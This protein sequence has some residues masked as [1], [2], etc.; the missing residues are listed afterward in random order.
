MSKRTCEVN[1]KTV[2]GKPLLIAACENGIAMEKM[3]L[4]LLEQGADAHAIDQ[5]T[6]RTALH[7]ACAGGLIN[8][9]RELL[10]R[11]ADVNARDNQQQTPAHAAITSKVFEVRRNGS[12]GLIDRS[13]SCQFFL[14]T[15]HVLIWAINR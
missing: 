4:M 12:K 1:G 7:A 6:G 5:E 13:S 11:G 10:Q 14:L 3:C 15:M 2:K 8:V 9:V